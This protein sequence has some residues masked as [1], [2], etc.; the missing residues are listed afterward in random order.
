[1]PCRKG[2]SDVSILSGKDRHTEGRTYIHK[3]THKDTH[4]GRHTERHLYVLSFLLYIYI[5]YI[6]TEGHTSR[7][8]CKDMH[9]EWHTTY[10]ETLAYTYTCIRAFEIDHHQPIVRWSVCLYSAR[11]KQTTVPRVH[12][13]ALHV[14]SSI[15]TVLNEYSTRKTRRNH[16][17]CT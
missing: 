17:A 16:I 15:N 14:V 1:M 7:M 11:P 2:D 13:T 6:Y 3:D 5:L 8:T 4:T 9:T 12:A 10:R